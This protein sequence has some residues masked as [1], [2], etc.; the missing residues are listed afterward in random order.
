MVDAPHVFND[1]TLEIFDRSSAIFLIVEFNIPSVRAARRSL[2]LFHKLNYLAVPD[3]V[4]IWICAEAR[5]STSTA[6][7]TTRTSSIM[8]GLIK[9]AVLRP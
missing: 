1:I 5:P 7:T 3:R 8:S 2:D 9:V 4:R 6:A